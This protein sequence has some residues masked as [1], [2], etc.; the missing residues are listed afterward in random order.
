[1]LPNI[2][3]KFADSNVIRVKQTFGQR[4]TLTVY[5]VLSKLTKKLGQ[6]CFFARRQAGCESSPIEAE[7][8]KLFWAVK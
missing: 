1:M 5:N 2:R 7:S 6:F 3:E 8:G 4:D